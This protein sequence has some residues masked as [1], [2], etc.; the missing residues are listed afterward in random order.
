MMTVKQNGGILIV[1]DGYGRLVRK[2]NAVAVTKD[3]LKLGNAA[4]YQK[5]GF[6]YTPRGR[7]L[8]EATRQ[9]GE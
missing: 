8:A 5:Y 9:M 1:R 6:H 7:T 3:W 2:L 4:F